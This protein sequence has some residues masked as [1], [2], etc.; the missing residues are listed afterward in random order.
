MT[1]RLY[2]LR[3]N[4]LGLFA[5]PI[6]SHNDAVA[7][8]QFGDIVQDEKMGL[9]AQHPDDFALYYLGD[10]D[11]ETGSFASVEPVCLAFGSDFLTPKDVNKH[12]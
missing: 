9:I 5:Q 10:F 6:I 12:E 4:R 2:S 11:D 8:R 7:I 3:D 1:K